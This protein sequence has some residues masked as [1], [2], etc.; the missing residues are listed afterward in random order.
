MKI[1]TPNHAKTL[2]TNWLIFLGMLVVLV[3]GMFCIW[4]SWKDVKPLIITTVQAQES[5]VD[6]DFCSLSVVECS[7][8]QDAPRGIVGLISR[9]T[10]NVP[11]ETAV[12]IARCESQLGKYTKNPTSSATGLFQFTK[13]TWEN[14][15][16]GDV[17]NDVD[18]I[19]C[20]DKLYPRHSSW[21]ECQ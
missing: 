18:Q 7:T 19:R 14:Y 15:C 8:E 2:R 13:G 10:V 16:E 11:D 4:L 9:Y 21:W 6:V 1:Y 17:T 5:P 12:R 3:L 20:F